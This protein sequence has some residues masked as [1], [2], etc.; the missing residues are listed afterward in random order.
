M[1]NSLQR[2][3]ATKAITLRRFSLPLWYF[4]LPPPHLFCCLYVVVCYLQC[5]FSGCI[6]KSF[7]FLFVTTVTSDV[8]F[9]ILMTFPSF[10][11]SYNVTSFSCWAE[12]CEDHIVIP[13]LW[14]FFHYFLFWFVLRNY[15]L[16][17]IFLLLFSWRMIKFCG[18][19]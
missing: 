4:F 9:P 7:E 11:L 14:W 3:Q 19:S 12:L 1:S 5:N 10:S 6:F 15:R 17:I 2:V 13:H 16:D 18:S 8:A